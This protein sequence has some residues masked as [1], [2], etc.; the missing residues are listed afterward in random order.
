MASQVTRFYPFKV[1]YMEYIRDLV[2]QTKVLD[3]DELRPRITAAC[4]TFTSDAAKH[5]S[6]GKVLSGRLLGYEG[7]PCRDL[8]RN[9]KTSKLFAYFG[10]VTVCL[11]I[12]VQEM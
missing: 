10:E 8:L 2:Y 11:C 5:L 3:V 6:K 12:L 7:H 9:I 4:E 1:L